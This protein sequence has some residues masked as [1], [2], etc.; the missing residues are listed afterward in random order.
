MP[1][2]LVMRPGP[3][4]QLKSVFYAQARQLA[5]LEF[6]QLLRTLASPGRSRPGLVMLLW[7]QRCTD[8]GQGSTGRATCIVRM[9][10]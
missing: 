10:L 1:V 3:V 8:P 6:S 7:C 4:A 5:D 2:Q 9:T